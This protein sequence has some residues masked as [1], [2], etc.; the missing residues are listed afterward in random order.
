MTT[1]GATTPGAVSGSGRHRKG[2]FLPGAIALLALLGLGVFLAGGGDLSHPAARTLDGPTIASQI[3]LGIQTEQNTAH[4]P[5]VSCPAAEPVRQGLQFTC[6]AG[7][8]PARTV[9]V[10]EVDGRGR[11]R[12][13]WTHGT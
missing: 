9:Y 7:P 6:T 4:A 2:Y 13:A 11:I 8:P 1:T 12:W 5:S 10:T 3:A